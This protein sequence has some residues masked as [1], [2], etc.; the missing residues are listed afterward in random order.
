MG[1]KWML[2]SKRLMTYE[3]HDQTKNDVKARDRCEKVT[4]KN[5]RNRDFVPY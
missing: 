4:G 5:A 2:A 1:S 3:G